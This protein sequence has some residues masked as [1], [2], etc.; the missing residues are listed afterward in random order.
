MDIPTKSR[1]ECQI[2]K[3]VSDFNDNK[4][5]CNNGNRIYATRCDE[6]IRISCECGYSKIYKSIGLLKSIDV[7][8]NLKMYC[9]RQT[10]RDRQRRIQDDIARKA[11][12]EKRLLEDEKLKNDKLFEDVFVKSSS[13]DELVMNLAK[14]EEFLTKSE[15][16]DDSTG[17]F[18]N[19]I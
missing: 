8:R 12:R 19:D 1:I 5:L 4:S 6:C 17:D 18:W 2:A 11:I 9:S 3:F 15:L 13:V 7:I 16:M 10:T 14:K